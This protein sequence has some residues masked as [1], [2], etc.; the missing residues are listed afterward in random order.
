MATIT[1]P[2]AHTR[3]PIL[4]AR[5][6]DFFYGEHQALFGVDLEIYPNEVIAFMGP[7]GC[8]KTTL[9]K[10]FNRMQDTIRDA[11]MTGEIA[12]LGQNIM[13]PDID[14]P[15]LRRRYGWVA[16]APNPFPMSIYE[17][18]AY[19]PRLHGLVEDGAEMD[20]HVR[21][22]LT[23]AD[24]WEEVEERLE[25]D[26]TALSGGQQQRLCIARALSVQ[27]EMLLMDEPCS[28]ID[29]IA[30]AHIEEL[31]AALRARLSI[32]IITHNLTQARRVAD[33]V[34]FFKMGRL[35]EVGPTD[36]L[37]AGPRHPDTADY[38]EGRIG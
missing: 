5:D 33:R 12:L 19:G 6:V 10:C 17:N 28:A 22:C 3:A 27:P 34:A 2:T 38:L 23:R 36:A 11:R 30:T 7:S 13:D 25:D 31:I 37:F 15:V 29:P 14:P 32:V 20:A 4:T 1:W 8:G 24:L 9:L 16:Q 26:G 21:D 35:V 18:V